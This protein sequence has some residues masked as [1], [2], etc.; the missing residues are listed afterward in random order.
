MQTIKIGSVIEILNHDSIMD[1]TYTSAD[2]EYYHERYPVGS[3]HGVLRYWEVSG[4]IELSYDGNPDDA[5]W[6]TF[7]PGEYKLVE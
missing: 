6:H 5:F 3:K 1:G 4:E 2:I 7:F